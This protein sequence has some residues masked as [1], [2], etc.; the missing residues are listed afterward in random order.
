MRA[1]HASHVVAWLPGLVMCGNGLR[2]LWDPHVPGDVPFI[3]P[4]AC[5]FAY[6]LSDST[7]LPW[8][9]KLL[10]DMTT[11]TRIGEEET[12]SI[13]VDVARRLSKIDPNIY[14]GFME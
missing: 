8:L 2:K 9:C 13:D 4:T 7:A 6:N 3:S 5:H 1:N 12:P 14:G 11:F 10:F